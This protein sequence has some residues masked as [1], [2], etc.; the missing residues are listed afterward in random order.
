MWRWKELTLTELK[1]FLALYFLTGVTRKP[2]LELYWDTREVLATPF[3]NQTMARDRFQLILRFIHFSDNGA[4]L[5]A[6]RLYKVRPVL[7]YLLHKFRTLYTPGKNIAID[8]GV[9]HWR[10]RLAFRTYNPQK[11]TKY[12]LKSFLLADSST[13]YGY[14]LKPYVG[15]KSPLGPTVETL[16]GNLKNKGYHLYMDNY[17]NSVKMCARLKRLG[18]QV[19]GTLRNH[20]GEPPCIRGA[21]VSTLKPGETIMRHNGDVM[22]TAWRD[23][24][25]VR[26]VSTI[27]KHRMVTVQERKKGRSGRVEVQKPLAVAEYNKYMNGVDR[28]DQM[29]SYY[30]FTRKTVKWTKKFVMYLFSIAM[31]NSFVLFTAAKGGQK[32]SLLPF[33]LS[34]VQSWGK[35]RDV[36]AQ[37]EDGAAASASQPDT[38]RAQRAPRHD[39]ESRLSVSLGRHELVQIPV[40]GKTLRPQKR[41]RVC[42]HAGVRRETRFVCKECNV[43]MHSECFHK[44][45]TKK[46]Y[47]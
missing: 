10:G 17:Y 35:L 24:R 28:L 36:R 32:K 15:E 5:E 27:H 22:V 18:T 19:C 44:Y 7:D 39:P 42:S 46:C 6:D 4:G 34:I 21:T 3:F 8:E 23:K 20:R 11:P 25:V 1:N 16:L 14:D 2:R 47:K 9:M 33:L 38:S 26:V 13:G 37:E 45:H 29:I 12:G 31:Y 30:P 40:S 43:P 41:C